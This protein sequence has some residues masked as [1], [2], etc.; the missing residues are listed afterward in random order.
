MLTLLS[1]K[2]FSTEANPDEL[3]YG[4]LV[5]LKNGGVNRLSIGVQ[6]FDA[7]LIE[8]NW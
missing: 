5:V 7:E 4:K 1:L 2:E 3:T 8:E 6:S